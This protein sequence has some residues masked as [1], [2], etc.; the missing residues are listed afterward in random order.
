MTRPLGVA[1]I[2]GAA[3]EPAIQVHWYDEPT[4]ILRQAKSLNYEAPFLFLLF[5]DER[6]LLLD[7]GA[8]A[9]PERFPLRATVDELVGQW[10]DRHPRPRY[11]LVVA[12]SHGHGDHVAADGQFADRPDTV[13][14]ARDLTRSRPSSAST[15]WPA[16]TVT[17]DLGGRRLEIIA[18]PGHHRAAVTIYDPGTG[19]LLTGDTVLPG[20]LY[21]EDRAAFLST[22]DR[23]V[24]F[25]A[26]RPVTHVLG[27]H[28]EMTN[29]A[30]PGLPARRDL[31]AERTTARA[32]TGPPDRD[33]RR[34]E[35]GRRPTRRAPVRRL[36]PLHRAPSAR[37]ALAL[38][39]RGRVHQTLARLLR[40][41]G[42]AGAAPRS[43]AARRRRWT[44]RRARLPDRRD[45]LPVLPLDAGAGAGRR[46]VHGILV[47]GPQLVVAGDI[48]S[49]VTDVAKRRTQRSVVVEAERERAEL[50]GRAAE[51]DRQVHRDAELRMGR[52]LQGVGRD[53]GLTGLVREQVD[54]VRGVVPEQVV[55]PVPR[56][57]ERVE[58]AAAQEVGLRL[59]VLDRELAGLDSPVHP[60]V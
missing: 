36:H 34:D 40:V 35:G 60:M 11:G 30:R 2:H 17:F 32:D 48:G 6:A 39:A 23:L 1:W 57:T 55:G 45:E 4:V 53:D 7:T 24:E 19:F 56:L 43:R 47:A 22:M 49:R 26:D 16:Q 3:G 54:G 20:R 29:E 41:A 18:S 38:M 27:C 31:P 14:V 37:G 21:V 5:G 58:V 8:V 9:D 25:A 59:Q 42:R 50:S 51:L 28:V 33:P 10:L 12:H 44:G 52:P 13:V 46:Q 15:S